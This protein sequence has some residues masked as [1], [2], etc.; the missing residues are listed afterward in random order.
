M[1]ISFDD[2]AGFLQAVAAGVQHL[3]DELLRQVGVQDSSK[4]AGWQTESFG[5]PIGLHKQLQTGHTAD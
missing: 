5:G 3:G 2:R 4:A 1:R